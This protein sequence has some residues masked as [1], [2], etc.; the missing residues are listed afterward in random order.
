MLFY[1]RGIWRQKCPERERLES[2]VDKQAKVWSERELSGE[3][4]FFLIE[5]AVVV[6]RPVR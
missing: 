2:K 3:H 4:S 1:V 5:I 6:I